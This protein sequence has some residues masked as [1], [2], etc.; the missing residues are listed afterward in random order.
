MEC[1]KMLIILYSFLIIYL[2]YR[3]KSSSKML[4]EEKLDNLEKTEQMIYQQGK[5]IHLKSLNFL[6]ENELKT[7]RKE[8]SKTNNYK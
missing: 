5:I 6:N 8:V 1:L 4:K 3:L 7:L 2:L